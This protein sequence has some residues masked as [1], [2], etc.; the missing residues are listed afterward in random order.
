M[1]LVLTACG[2]EDPAADTASEPESQEPPPALVIGGIPDQEVALLEERF[3]G[4]A[5][6]LS[7]EV[8]IPVR[9]QPSV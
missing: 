3:D 5:T 9:Y 8:G 2:G 7:D 4:V 6:Y 1:A